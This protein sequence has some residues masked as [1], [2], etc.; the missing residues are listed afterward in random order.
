MDGRLGKASSGRNGGIK[1]KSRKDGSS[2]SGMKSRTILVGVIM[3]FASMMLCMVALSDMTMFSTDDSTVSGGLRNADTTASTTNRIHAIT[4]YFRQAG[5]SATADER[6]IEQS[7]SDGSATDTGEGGSD[8]HKSPSVEQL[9]DITG[10]KT[11]EDQKGKKEPPAEKKEEETRDD[12][13]MPLE[14]AGNSQEETDKTEQETGVKDNNKNEKDQDSVKASEQQ[15]GTDNDGEKDQESAKTSER[16]G[17]AQSGEDN[18]SDKEQ[19]STKPSEQT[20]E[21]SASLEWRSGPVRW[22]PFPSSKLSAAE[23][24]EL[25][26]PSKRLADEAHIEYHKLEALHELAQDADKYRAKLPPNAISEKMTLPEDVPVSFHVK[27]HHNFLWGRKQFRHNLTEWE[28]KT[29][30]AEREYHVQ[31]VEGLSDRSTFAS[32]SAE[33]V[34]RSFQL[35][36]TT[37]EDELEEDIFSQ[38]GRVLEYPF[39]DLR[40]CPQERYP[41]MYFIIPH[42]NRVT[43]LLRLLSSVR[44]ATARC[45]ET[46]PWYH[47]LCMYVSDY[48]TF[49]KT[50]LS[51]DLEHVWRDRVRLISRAPATAPWIKAKTYNSAL[52]Y[53][54]TPSTRSL[55][56][57]IDAD[58]VAMNTTFIDN[59]LAATIAGKRVSFPIVMGTRSPIKNVDELFEHHFNGTIFDSK[60]SWIRKWGVGMTWFYLYD[61]NIGFFGPSVNKTTWGGE[62]NLFF[63][64]F[65]ILSRKKETQSPSRYTDRSLWH[66]WHPQVMNWK[67]SRDGLTVNKAKHPSVR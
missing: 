34:Q 12:K 10:P 16:T 19:G 15:S 33:L 39:C 22:M 49:S 36:N 57:H 52:R 46:P 2:L 23:Y 67:K 11:K 37:Y 58:L 18:K 44:N 31:K 24:K 66:I 35:L 26:R 61:D 7:G 27:R 42:R 30:K 9:D 45:D 6:E 3:C 38:K 65:I 20:I 1:A 56:F 29:C 21:S 4:S 64:Q 62:D 48:D 32:S 59:G 43:N 54:P 41:F 28:T 13:G 53:I 60:V 14:T 25:M 51:A 47:C 17:A 55:V 40:K 5:G 8:E 50:P 63:R